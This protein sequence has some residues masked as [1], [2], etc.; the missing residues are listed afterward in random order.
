M[1]W[2]WNRFLIGICVVSV[3]VNAY[4][5]WRSKTLGH[6]LEIVGVGLGLEARGNVD[7]ALE[8]YREAVKVSPRFPYGLALL[9]NAYHRLGKDAEALEQYE[10]ALKISPRHFWV[11]YL[12]G[13]MLEEQGHYQEA[14]Q[15]FTELI[16]MQDNPYHSNKIFGYTQYQGMCYADLGYC[17]AKIG[18]KRKALESYE[19][20][21]SLNPSAQDRQQIEQYLRQLKD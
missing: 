19:R 16:H 21:L 7:A 10:K 3:A 12:L 1:N 18:D 5:I 8:K 17:Y 4:I 6:A 2:K 15:K 11:H 9:G 14:I 20:Y 13:R